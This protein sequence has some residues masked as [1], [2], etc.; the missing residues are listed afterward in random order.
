ML[1]TRMMVAAM[2][3]KPGQACRAQADRVGVWEPCG[4][5]TPTRSVRSGSESWGHV[6]VVE[7]FLRVSM[8]RPLPSLTTDRLGP[9]GE[10]PPDT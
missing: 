3:T 4:S 2:K 1:P 7:V 9:D 8:R 5:Q 10:G 6:G